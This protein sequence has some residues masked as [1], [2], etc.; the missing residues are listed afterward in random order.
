MQS[1]MQ[2]FFIV[3]VCG[4]SFYS[5]FSGKFIFC[6]GYLNKDC[7]CLAKVNFKKIRSLNHSNKAITYNVC[8]SKLN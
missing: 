5:S 6:M 2:L 8:S 3:V 1:T 4:S 7:L